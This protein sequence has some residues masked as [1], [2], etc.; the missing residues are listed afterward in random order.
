[1]ELVVGKAVFISETLPR[2]FIST[3]QHIVFIPWLAQ[4]LQIFFKVQCFPHVEDFQILPYL[5]GL[6]S[7]PSLNFCLMSIYGYKG[8]SK[9]QQMVYTFF[10]RATYNEYKGAMIQPLLHTFYNPSNEPFSWHRFPWQRVSGV[11]N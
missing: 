8:L 9:D 2:G 10:H 6:N 5:A 1:M 7:D 3:F 11:R 4:V